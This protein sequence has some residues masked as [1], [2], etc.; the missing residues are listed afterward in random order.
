MSFKKIDQKEY[1]K[2]YL[3]NDVTG[4]KKKKKKQSKR[5]V[6]KRYIRFFKVKIKSYK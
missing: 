1:L 6:R 2:K 5:S 4:E 3:S